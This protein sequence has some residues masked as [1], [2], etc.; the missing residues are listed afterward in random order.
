[1][2]QDHRRHAAVHPFRTL[3]RTGFVRGTLQVLP[4][5]S[6]GFWLLAIVFNRLNEDHQTWLFFGAVLPFAVGC[7]IG[8]LFLGHQVTGQ[9]DVL[10]SLTAM[11]LLAAVL[12]WPT[13]ILS[14]MTLDPLPLPMLDE[15][16]PAIFTV[17]ITFFTGWIFLVWTCSIIFY[18]VRFRRLNSAPQ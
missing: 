3:L 9:P 1:M 10:R 6:I 15:R 13:M 5:A 14:V 7:C 4:A 12:V 17:W 11:T 2:S 16:T 8:S 18:A